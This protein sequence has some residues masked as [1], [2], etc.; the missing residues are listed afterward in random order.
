MDDVLIIGGGI[1]GSAL[2][3][4]CARRGLAVRVLDR[5]EAG[6]TASPRA[7]GLV[8]VLEPTDPAYMAARAAALAETAAWVTEEGVAAQVE[9]MPCGSLNPAVGPEVLPLYARAGVRAEWWP[10]ARVAVEEPALRLPGPGALHL[11]ADAGVRPAPY[12]AAVRSA[13]VRAGAVWEEA[14]VE[15]LRAV[16]GGWQAG[17]RAARRVVVA[18]GAWSPLLVPGLPVAPVRGTVLETEAL[19]PLLRRC[20]PTLRQLPDGR[21]WIGASHEH[22]GY[23][24]EPDPDVAARLRAEAVALLPALATAAIART[25]AGI[26]PVPLIGLPLC[27]P[28][29]GAEGL[30][31]AVTHSG[32][33]MAHWL[34]R[35]LARSLTG[36]AVPD[37]APFAP[38]P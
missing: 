17:G 3:L 11:P 38:R 30:H 9:W 12:L 4:H 23:A 26:R 21:V 20:T 34:G 37:L 16:P 31:V 13:A 25:W 19:P 24:A 33:T 35:R 18:A 32:V 7:F 28:W 8:N 22:A 5:G 2:A 1:I 29:P 36:E 14:G 6:G 10:A 15:A 27:G